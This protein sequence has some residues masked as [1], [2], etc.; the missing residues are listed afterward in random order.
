MSEIQLIKLAL[1][2]FLLAAL[3]LSAGENLDL[4]NVQNYLLQSVS[5][6]IVEGLD[7]LRDQT[8]LSEELVYDLPGVVLGQRGEFPFIFNLHS[9]YKF[10]K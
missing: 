5:H 1:I 4:S 10:Y 8:V 2:F 7:L 9:H 6:E 3:V